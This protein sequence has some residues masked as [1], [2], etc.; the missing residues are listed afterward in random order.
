MADVTFIDHLDVGLEEAGWKR[1]FNR[2]DYE[3]FCK[4]YRDPCYYVITGD[5][6][7]EYSVSTL[8]RYNRDNVLQIFNQT[9]PTIH[10]GV[11]IKCG[12]PAHMNDARPERLMADCNDWYDHWQLLQ[13]LN[14]SWGLLNPEGSETEVPAAVTATIEAVEVEVESVP[15][16]EEDYPNHPSLKFWQ[17]VAKTVMSKRTVN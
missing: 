8:S 7:G 13:T 11:W 17:G 14:E 10:N 3:L 9:L 6:D 5:K 16:Y 1:L 15:W 12:D 2:M 4:D